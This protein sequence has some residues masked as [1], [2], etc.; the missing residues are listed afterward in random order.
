MTDENRRKN[1][2][3]QVER[4]S[5][6]FRAADAL[7]GL[8]LYADCISR[9]Y[10]AAFHLARALLLSRGVEPE[11]HAGTVHQL[12]AEFIRPG[13][14]STSFNRLF[15]GLQRSREFADYDAA[16]AFSLDDARAELEAART[17]EAAAIELL[18]AEGWLGQA[19]D[20][21]AP[22]R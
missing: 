6:A 9:G 4:A 22:G 18:R 20:E 15:A 11:S 8:G 5:E 16:V 17:F 12:N 19:T 10:Y 2:L 7:L 13:L 1:L 3:Q 14:L 21:S